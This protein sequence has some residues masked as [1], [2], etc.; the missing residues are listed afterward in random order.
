MECSYFTGINIWRMIMNRMNQNYSC[1][2]LNGIIF[3]LIVGISS[4]SS[5]RVTFRAMQDLPI[6]GSGNMMVGDMVFTGDGAAV[7]YS[8]PQGTALRMMFYRI[9][10]NAQTVVSKEHS[11]EPLSYYT[12]SICWDGQNFGVVASVFTQAVF[13]KLNAAGDI[14]LGPITLP[15]LPTGDEVGRTAAFKI[16]WTGNDYAIFGLWLEKQ[17]PLQDLTQGNFYTHLNYWLIDGAG[18]QITHRHLGNL[19]P[20]TYPGIEGSE[21]IYYDV[22]W[23]GERFFLAYYSESQTGPPLSSY[24]KIFDIG[25]NLI[26]G[27]RP[28]FA[29]QVAQ[30]PRLAWNGRTIG[31]TA[32]KTISMPSP[33]AGNYMYVRFF[34]AL[35]NPRAPETEYGALLG[36][37]PTLFWADDRFITAYCIIYDWNNLGYA[38]MFNEFDEFGRRLRQEYPLSDALG[39]T[40][41]GRMVLGY[42]LQFVGGG[43]VFYG[44]GQNSDA[45]GITQNPLVFT[46]TG[47]ATITRGGQ[48]FDVA[49]HWNAPYGRADLLNVLRQIR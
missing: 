21:K 35:G 3:I 43:N 23:T 8:R 49:R 26:A 7:V 22:V 5:A 30:G 48:I 24:Y 13:L 41:L 28:V 9:N 34:D 37:G 27:E 6:S 14:V 29:A 18:Q 46:L 32:L 33:G 2:L 4:W 31:L 10:Q 40:L 16:I 38:L 45:W 1:R 20:M 19:A 42:D 17:Y 15:G 25:G 39:R 36:F 44:K 11:L 47:D 12:P